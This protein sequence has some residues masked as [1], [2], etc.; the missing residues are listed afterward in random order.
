MNRFISDEEQTVTNVTLRHPFHFKTAY[1]TSVYTNFTV[2]F[3][4][5]LDYIYY[6]ADQLRIVQVRFNEDWKGPGR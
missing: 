2:G 1:D 5:C 3:K 6:D 4:G